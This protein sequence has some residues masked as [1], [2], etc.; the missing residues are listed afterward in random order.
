MLG[1]ELRL[2][3]VAVVST[4]AALDAGTLLEHVPGLALGTLGFVTLVWRLVKDNTA[5]QVIRTGFQA[6]IDAE[7]ARADRAELRTRQLEE[8]VK[9]LETEIEGDDVDAE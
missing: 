2:V 4:V 3:A 8:R 6:V 1:H 7:R 9:D 5:D